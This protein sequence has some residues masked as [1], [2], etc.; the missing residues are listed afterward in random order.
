M[1]NYIDRSDPHMD[2]VTLTVIYNAMVN[3]A[4]EMGLTMM[5][6]SYSPIFNEA[7]DFSVVIFDAKARMMA[8]AEFCPSQIGAVRYT[9]GWTIEEMG[10]ENFRP[11]DVI[12]H[13][14]PYRGN[15]HIPEHMVVKPVYAGG[16]LIAFVATIGHMAEI[17]GKAP[18]GFAADA[19][20]VYQEGLR[21]PPVK[22]FNRGEY[23]EDVWRIVLANHRTPRNTWGDF[24]A[25]IGSLE[26]AERRII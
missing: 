19:T 22:I 1:V 13:N 24:H 17:G 16:E 2:S 23:V 21:L 11:G 9:V 15:G 14:D 4:R 25:M 12:I 20:D 3:I 10:A 7:L 6:T 5:R 8:Q 26:M 18:G